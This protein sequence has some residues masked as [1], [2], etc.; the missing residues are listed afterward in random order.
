MFFASVKTMSDYAYFIEDLVNEGK[1]K[2]E[3]S[4]EDYLRALW[5]LILKHKNISPTWMLLAYLVEEAFY[6]PPVSFNEDWM[7]YDKPPD[8]EA[9]N[10]NQA[11]ETLQ[12]MILYQIAELHSMGAAGTLDLPGNVLFLGVV[13][14]SGHGWYNFHPLSFLRQGVDPTQSDTNHVQC[15][16]YDLAVILWLGQIYE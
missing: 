10:P 3:G 12:K 14:P 11:F 13:G 8:L 2:F 5:G 9:D 7:V 16:W 6:A 15:D 1:V 4:L